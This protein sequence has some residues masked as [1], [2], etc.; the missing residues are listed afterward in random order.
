MPGKH[1]PAATNTHATTEELFIAVFFYAVG[2]VS[3]IHYVDKGKQ[4][5]GSRVEAGSNSS[6]VAL[7][8]V[9]GEEKGTQC[10]GI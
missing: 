4:A 6:T 5:R 9:G 8:V 3:D 1:V 10:L 2:V 7:R